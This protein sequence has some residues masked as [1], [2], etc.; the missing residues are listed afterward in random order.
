MDNFW[1][2]G[3]GTFGFRAARALRKIDSANRL[4]IVEKKKAVC[5]R[6]SREGIKAVCMDGT[7][8]LASRLSG[9]QFPDWIVPAIPLHVAFEWMR[10]KMSATSTVESVRI[11]NDIVGKLP[12]PAQGETGQFF[13]SIADF[14]CPPNCSEPDD[15]CTHTGKPRPM[16]L[17]EYL[18]SIRV[19]NFESIVIRSQQL[20][21]GV[22]GYPP[23]ALFDALDQIRDMQSPVLLSTACSCHGVMNA[24]K[25]IH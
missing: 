10:A 14:K 15:I 6:L 9:K 7:Q 25:S 2:I 19:K 4:T 22:G 13:I 1:I 11:P 16:I 5:A 18:K 12:N 23:A 20:A 24:F 8:Y 17:H 3:G 21:P